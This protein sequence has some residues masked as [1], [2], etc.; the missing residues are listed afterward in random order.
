MTPRRVLA[1]LFLAVPLA[2]TG[3]SD[4]E[5]GAAGTAEGP[6]GRAAAPAA[7]CGACVFI[8]GDVTG[9]VPGYAYAVTS[10]IFEVTSIA[11]RFVLALRPAGGEDAIL[12]AGQDVGPTGFVAN[13]CVT[14]L[15]GVAIDVAIPTP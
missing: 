11:E 14:R 2:L 10:G 1:L 15:T 6:G 4:G 3:C 13:G 8:A 9:G 5:G 7:A 12:L